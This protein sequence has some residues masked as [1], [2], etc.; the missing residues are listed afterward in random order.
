M[1]N[2][3]FLSLLFCV[4]A[5]SSAY[6][7]SDDLPK[8]EVAAEFTAI[9]RD[10]FQGASADLGLGAR[11]TFNF[12]KNVSFESAGYFFPRRCLSCEH[13]GRTT[14]VLAG[15]KVGKRF[16]RWGIFGKARP[17]VVSFSQGDFNVF[18][19]NDGSAFPF[20][21]EVN[22]LNSFALDLGAVVEVYPSRRIVTRFDFGDTLIHFGNRTR[23]F[24]AFDPSTG[25]TTLV[26]FT[27]PGKTTHNF[28][29]ITS[30]GLRF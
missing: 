15:V 2:V 27:I 10:D 3:V 7:Q 1:K 29:F 22:R 26:P 16:Q 9:N 28:Q 13:N 24:F 21:F 11:F 4:V 20:R 6:A 12:N 8:Y 23:N 5:H 19:V 30:V 17:G 25:N 14:E 18:P